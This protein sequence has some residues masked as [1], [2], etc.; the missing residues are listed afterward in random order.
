MKAFVRKCIETADKMTQASASHRPV[1]KVSTPTE[2]RKPRDMQSNRKQR[3]AALQQNMEEDG[4]DGVVAASDKGSVE[5]DSAVEQEGEP[6]ST[7]P[8]D[9]TAAVED[10]LV[11]PPEQPQTPDEQA[12]S[13]ADEL[14]EA[15]EPIMPIDTAPVDTASTDT[16]STDTTSTDT[17]PV[18]EDVQNQP[19]P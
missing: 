6:E 5:V 9:T 12:S 7:S 1:P 19:K 15:E 18:N 2:E 4:Q 8:L 11:Q 17:A 13:A 3:R 14:A 16:T 10:E